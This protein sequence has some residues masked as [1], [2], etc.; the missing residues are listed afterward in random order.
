MPIMN[1]KKA[2]EL[3][4]D[5]ER[6]RSLEMYLLTFISVNCSESEIADRMDVNGKVRAD[7]FL[8]KTC[9]SRIFR[10]GNI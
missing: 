6:T 1:K 4:R 2:A 10:S 3:I 7:I 5:L 8:K 9:P